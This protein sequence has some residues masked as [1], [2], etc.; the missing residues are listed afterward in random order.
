LNW[1]WLTGSEIQSIMIKAGSMAVSRQE[2]E[3]LRV[4]PLVLE[5][6]KRRLEPMW[7]GGGSHC[8]SPT[9]THFFQQGHTY[10][11]KAT[12]PSTATPWAKLIQVTT[13]KVLSFEIEHETKMSAF[14][15]SMQQNKTKQNNSPPSPSFHTR[16]ICCSYT[17]VRC[18]CVWC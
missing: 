6:A 1:G 14:V 16:S 8:P 9:V 18:M 17:F 3:E 13:P 2:L 5:A 15:A 7:L 10:S 12:P 11:N 4:L